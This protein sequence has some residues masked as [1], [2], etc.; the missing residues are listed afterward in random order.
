MGSLL[1]FFDNYSSDVMIFD[2]ALQ[3]KWIGRGVAINKQ[4]KGCN[5][6]N[7]K[8]SSTDFRVVFLLL[9]IKY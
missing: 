6:K 4:I 9:F 8:M 1:Y 2:D 5:K 3:P 7:S